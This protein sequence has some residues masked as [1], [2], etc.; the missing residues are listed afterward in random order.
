MT[1][2]I[3]RTLKV[4]TIVNVGESSC[5]TG[6]HRRQSPE[7]RGIQ[8]S[9]NSAGFVIA[10]LRVLNGVKLHSQRPPLNSIGPNHIPGGIRSA[11][12]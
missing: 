9:A 3:Q 2:R 11:E 8:E 1:R 12:T 7:T 10:V 6:K 5:F 4:G